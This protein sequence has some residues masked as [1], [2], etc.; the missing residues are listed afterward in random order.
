MSTPPNDDPPVWTDLVD[1]YTQRLMIEGVDP[2]DARVQA[3]QRADDLLYDE[4]YKTNARIGPRHYRDNP[5]DAEFLAC[6]LRAGVGGAQAFALYPDHIGCDGC[7]EE[8]DRRIAFGRPDVP[9]GMGPAGLRAARIRY[10]ERYMVSAL[11][12][13]D[14]AMPAATQGT[15]LHTLSVQV[16]TMAA[17]R[18][19]MAGRLE[20]ALKT[21][22]GQLERAR[23]PLA[24]GRVPSW[25][26]LEPDA[27][28]E[29]AAT[30]EGLRMLDK[31][32]AEM[33]AVLTMTCTQVNRWLK[34]E[35]VTGEPAGELAVI[36]AACD[37]RDL[38]NIPAVGRIH[39]DADTALVDA[40]DTYRRGLRPVLDVPVNAEQCTHGGDCTV[41]PEVKGLHDFTPTAAV[42]LGVVL[43][44][45]QAGPVDAD[46]VRRIADRLGV[47]PDTYA[48]ADLRAAEMRDAKRVT[49]DQ[50]GCPGT[51]VQDNGNGPHEMPCRLAAGH[52]G[53]HRG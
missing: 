40:V 6:G 28:V 8:I 17:R 10:A 7:R 46:D 33:A 41:H 5:P 16:R 29:T 43:N 53:E 13:P 36:A 25:T 27:A 52:D 26:L 20:Q 42:A 44:A 48:D 38:R 19:R 3:Q 11:G 18:N 35:G 9:H 24:E 51:E 39:A 37:W 30:A 31:V 50:G 21:Q 15:P 45:A 12:L 23:G 22:Q 2:A 1:H 49:L 4:A 32:L 34:A 14:W 47:V